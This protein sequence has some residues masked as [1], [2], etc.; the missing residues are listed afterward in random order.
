MLMRMRFGAA[1]REPAKKRDQLDRHRGIGVSGARQRTT[2]DNIAIEFFLDLAHE[3]GGRF[4]AW[5]HLTPGKFPFARKVLERR[6]LR[7]EHATIALDHGGNH[8][9]RRRRRDHN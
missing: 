4:L 7:H 6:S 8:G 1:G 5:L 9:E 3:G 2:D